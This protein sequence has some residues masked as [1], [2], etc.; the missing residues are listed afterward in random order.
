MEDPDLK[1]AID[2]YSATAENGILCLKERIDGLERKLDS[3]PKFDHAIAYEQCMRALDGIYKQTGMVV[4]Y[5]DDA[6]ASL[7][8]SQLKELKNQIKDVCSDSRMANR[9]LLLEGG[10]KVK[11]ID[12]SNQI[13]QLLEAAHYHQTQANKE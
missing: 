2:D 7:T 8:D 3:P 5:L 10:L 6:E 1:A 13:S 4:F 12:M 9:P 11:T